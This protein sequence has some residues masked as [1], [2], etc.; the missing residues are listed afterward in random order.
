MK[1]TPII[2][3][4]IPNRFEK[5]PKLTFFIFLAVILIIVD[6]FVGTIF[7][8][9]PEK[10][11][12]RIADPYINHTLTPN[13]EGVEPWS[14]GRYKIYT[15]NLGF[16]DS[17]NRNVPLEMPDK[18]RI[19]FIGDSFTEGI[20][21]AYDKTWV[22]L[23][24]QKLGPIGYDI[25]NAG[26]ASYAPTIYYLKTKYLLEHGLKFNE[27]VVFVD[28]SDVQNEL[29]YQYWKPTTPYSLKT[30]WEK[31]SH[32]V[33]FFFEHHSLTYLHLVRPTLFGFTSRR[34][35]TLLIDGGAKNEKEAKYIADMGQWT[36]DDEVWNDWGQ[37]GAKLELEWM[38]KLYELCKE[39]N[40][41][42]SVAVYPWPIH[43]EKRDLNSRQ[44]A[45]WQKFSKENNLNFYNFFPTF[46][47]TTT[48]F[49]KE[50]ELYFL[51]NDT[52]W[53]EAGHEIIAKEWLKQYLRNNKKK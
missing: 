52:H 20:G 46:I 31:Y 4:Q 14:G 53:N 40:I 10:Q 41:K 45:I 38:K 32:K 15:N 1:N 21:I 44:V 36:F 33:D 17:L 9:K 3:A 35:Y 19:I 5:H 27:L 7:L 39:Y 50:K 29:A 8:A 6:L 2:T 12:G 13:F 49:K 11:K 22:G 47:S 30:L 24:E 48:P 28:I 51:P 43:V 37:D 25:L 16:K 18:H 34:L 42:M 26:V 23:I